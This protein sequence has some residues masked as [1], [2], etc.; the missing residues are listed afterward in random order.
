[1]KNGILDEL[2]RDEPEIEREPRVL[3]PVEQLVDGAAR[4]P[5]GGRGR[6]EAG[7]GGADRARLDG[8]VVRGAGAGATA[9]LR[10]DPAQRHDLLGVVEALAVIAAMGDDQP[11]PALPRAQRARRDAKLARDHSDLLESGRH[12]GSVRLRP[13]RWFFTIARILNPGNPAGIAE[14]LDDV[15]AAGRRLESLVPRIDV[16]G[17]DDETDRVAADCFVRREGDG[18][19]FRTLLAGAFADDFKRL[20][21]P[22]PAGGTILEPLVHLAEPGLVRSLAVLP[23]H[24]G[25]PSDSE[26]EL[27]NRRSGRRPVGCAAMNA[28]GAA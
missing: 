20:A 26:E 4:E 5:R 21:E 7:A 19:P 27:N 28:W 22:D 15:V 18:D 14:L 6:L 3:A 24:E 13:I 11:I 1:M 12:P 23:R 16:A 2:A 8:E 9:K 17:H 25:H 10:E